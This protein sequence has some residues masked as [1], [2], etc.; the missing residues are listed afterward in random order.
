MTPRHCTH[1]CFLVG[2]GGHTC[3][4]YRS[5]PVLNAKRANSE[6]KR[7]LEAASLLYYKGTTF[8][9]FPEADAWV[10]PGLAMPLHMIYIMI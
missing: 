2:V 7:A 9:C 3:A 10:G 8:N 1:V 4:Q 5:S 6:V